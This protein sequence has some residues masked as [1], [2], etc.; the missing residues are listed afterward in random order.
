M[1]SLP[2]VPEGYVL[3]EPGGVIESGDLWSY[4]SSQSADWLP[5]SYVGEPMPPN[6]QYC[7]KATT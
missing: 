4:E 6:N 1:T 5:T 2:P 7:R 3:L